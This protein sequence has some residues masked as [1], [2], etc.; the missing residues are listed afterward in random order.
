MPNYTSQFKDTHT[1][2]S[3]VKAS[4][5][6]LTGSS[7]DKEKMV[8]HN[9]RVYKHTDGERHTLRIN[10]LRYIHSADETIRTL[11]DVLSYTLYKYIN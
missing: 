4:V 1:H 6:Y 10:V 2:T 3:R 5:E 11:V 8:Q 9:K 7:T